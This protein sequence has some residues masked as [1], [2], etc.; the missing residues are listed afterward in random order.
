MQPLRGG[1]GSVIGSEIVGS[2]VSRNEIPV[3]SK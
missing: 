3:S 2:P 1:I